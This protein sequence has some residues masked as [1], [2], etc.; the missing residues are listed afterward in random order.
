MASY[1]IAEVDRGTADGLTSANAKGASWFNSGSNWSATP[2]TS[3]KISPG[4]KVWISGTISTPLV[5]QRGGSPGNPITLTFEPGAKMSTGT[6]TS[7]AILAEGDLFSGLKTD[8]VVDGFADGR[9]EAT[10]A[11]TGLTYSTGGYGV[12]MVGVSRVEVKNLRV[13]DLFVRTVGNDKTTPGIAISCVPAVNAAFSDV[14]VHD[15]IIQHCFCGVNTTYNAQGLSNLSVYN[16]SIRYINWGVQCGSET[17]G[18]TVSGIQIY[19][20]TI[21]DFANWDEPST[22]NHHHN[23]VFVWTNNGDTTG[24]CTGLRIHGNTIGSG[25]G[26]Y[27]TSGIYVSAPGHR[28]EIWV[29]N[30]LFYSVGSN[31]TNGDIFI[32]PGPGATARIYNNTHI[33][34]NGI[35][36]GYGGDHGGAQSLIIRNC[37]VK[38]TGK[39]AVYVSYGT[40]VTISSDRNVWYGLATSPTGFSLSSNS[41]ASFRTFAQWQA[42]GYD[43]NSDYEINPLLDGEG[44]P[45]TG[46]PAIES[47]ED[48]SG[49][50]TTDYDEVTRVAPWDI[51]A[52]E[53]ASGDG[54][55]TPNPLGNRGT[56]AFIFAG[57]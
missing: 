13:F 39:I 35:A 21:S 32:V 9:I 18:A 3:G 14:S 41:S 40:S 10:A 51:G 2:A 20:N 52:F 7:S 46:S 37:I 38:G 44:R 12:R 6:W 22:N 50:F 57:Y 36:I 28:S 30:N 48:L 49:Y 42:L 34:D 17:P 26:S 25:Y 55:S 53:S 11:G 16:N 31:P 4:D 56:R 27:A 19:G 15:N 5:F 29:Y 54:S 45:Q 43:A 33:G 23:A 24:T 8:I 1:Y 47:G